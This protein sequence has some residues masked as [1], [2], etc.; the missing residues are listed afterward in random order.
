MSEIILKN[1]DEKKIFKEYEEALKD[2]IKQKQAKINL[3][4]ILENLKEYKISKE[5]E[6]KF[7]EL[8]SNIITNEKYKTL[9]ENFYI[10]NK[11][12]NQK[13]TLSNGKWNEYNTASLKLSDDNSLYWDLYK[14]GKQLAIFHISIKENGIVYKDHNT[15]L[16]LSF[17]SNSIFM[18]NRNKVGIEDKNSKV[19]IDDNFNKELFNTLNI[20]KKKYKIIEKVIFGN[21]MSIRTANIFL[22]V[23]N[24]LNHKKLL[25]IA[26]MN[27]HRIEEVG[28]NIDNFSKIAKDIINLTKEESE[29][30]LLLTDIEPKEYLK[31]SF[32]DTVISKT[33]RKFRK[34]K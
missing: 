17:F 16:R 29:Q 5:L 23:L 3:K 21:H 24:N 10:L 34:N 31:T 6:Q 27:T 26:I 18:Y 1:E 32:I 30:I 7:L 2:P 13:E 22:R 9:R 14:N 11:I 25:N 33:K 28:Y 20:M 8:V 12:L 4:A 19:F 15:E